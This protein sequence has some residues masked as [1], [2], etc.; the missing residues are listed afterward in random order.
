MSGRLPFTYTQLI[1]GILGLALLAVGGVLTYYSLGINWGLGS[2]ALT[3]MGVVIT[4]FGLI[5]LTSKEG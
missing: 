5:L 1:V 3:P 2:K 4:L